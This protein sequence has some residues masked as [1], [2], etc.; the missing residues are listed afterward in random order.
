VPIHVLSIGAHP[1][2]AEHSIG[3]TAALLRE[4]GDVVRFVSV[5]DGSKGHYLPEYVSDPEAL[6]HRRYG[7][8]LAATEIIGATY[9]TM[10]LPDGEVYVTPANTEEMVRLIRS[11]GEPGLGPDL[12]LLNRPTDY[13]RDHRYTA[14]LVLDATYILTVPPMCPDTRHLDRMPVFAYWHDNFTEGGAFRP[15]I[16]IPI[17]RV[18]DKKIDMVCAHE[19][20]FFEWIPYNLGIL[21]QVP[22]D[23]D[24]RREWLGA[25][26][27]GMAA[28]IAKKYAD[29]LPPKTHYAE[30]F[31]LSEYGRRPDPDEM[32]ALFPIDG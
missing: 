22:K 18:M 29:R 27:R 3:G 4:R 10:H 9:D 15:D 16:V 13:H 1:D 20:Q 31:Q 25:R 19:S 26:Y 5:S 23:Y 11:F 6:A 14:Q 32:R 17:D 30:A 12:V 21:D 28:S 8:A 2:D 7:E 24:E